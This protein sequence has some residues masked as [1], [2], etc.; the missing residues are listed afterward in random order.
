[1]RQD[2]LGRLN[3]DT[4]ADDTDAGGGNVSGTLA[5]INVM[6]PFLNFGGFGLFGIFFI[7]NLIIQLFTGG[8]NDLFPTTAA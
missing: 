4:H 1:M 7:I 5:E 2:S 3:F 6:L 8:L